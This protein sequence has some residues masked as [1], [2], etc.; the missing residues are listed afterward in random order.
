MGKRMNTGK[1]SNE[2]KHHLQVPHLRTAQPPPT[3]ES[4]LTPSSPQHPQAL[5]KHP[6]SRL[7][8]AGEG[9]SLARYSSLPETGALSRNP[10]VFVGGNVTR[11]GQWRGRPSRYRPDCRL[12]L[13]V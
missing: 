3:E 8:S 4:S 6:S 5:S 7:A 1:R 9:G 12:V 2:N 13:W 10:H 11:Y